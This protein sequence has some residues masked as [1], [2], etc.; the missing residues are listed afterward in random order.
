[1]GQG[2]CVLHMKR[3]SA[4]SLSAAIWPMWRCS[5]VRVSDGAYLALHDLCDVLCVLDKL[6]ADQGATHRGAVD[7]DML[8]EQH[9][10]CDKSR[11]DAIAEMAGEINDAVAT[12]FITTPWRLLY[13]AD[14]ALACCFRV[15]CAGC[16]GRLHPESTFQDVS[17]GAELY[18]WLDKV[19]VSQLFA[20]SWQTR[21]P[22]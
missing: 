17:N 1:M 20:G 19:F 6:V 5:H 18:E 14:A 11:T 21:V 9:Y 3:F 13:F 7:M 8:L 22:V 16:L 15:T 10:R 4:A 12:R 2:I